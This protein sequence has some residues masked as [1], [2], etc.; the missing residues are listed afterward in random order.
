MLLHERH[1]EE[2]G[3]VATQDHAPLDVAEVTAAPHENAYVLLAQREG[4]VAAEHHA[5]RAHRLDEQAQ[6]P[7]VKDGRV[8]GETVE[9]V[10][11]R[12]HRTTASNRALVPGVLQSAE[13]EGEGA[14]SVGKADA[15]AFGQPIESPAQ[16][17]EACV[18]GMWRVC[19]G[20][21]AMMGR[22]RGL[23][24]VRQHTIATIER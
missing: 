9:V 8:D 10:R 21:K 3:S 16:Y 24:G 20:M 12:M 19:D 5:M 4:I 2:A 11:G 15:Q 14:A 17:L 13:Q 18:E 23:A 22:A 6:G 7:L 1:A